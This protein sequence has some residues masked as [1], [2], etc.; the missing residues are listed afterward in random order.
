MGFRL[1]MRKRKR[2]GLWV[3]EAGECVDPGASGIAE[4]EQLGHLVKGFAGSVVKGPPKQRIRPV[5][6]RGSMRRAGEIKVRVPAGD[7]QREGPPSGESDGLGPSLE[8]RPATLRSSSEAGQPDRHP[9]RRG[10][11]LHRPTSDS[12]CASDRYGG[13][14]RP[15]SD[16]RRIPCQ[17][18]LAKD[19]P[20]I[21]P[22]GSAHLRH[23]C[24]ESQPRAKVSDLY[25][26]G[27]QLPCRR[28]FAFRSE[29]VHQSGHGESHLDLL[30]F[31]RLWSRNRR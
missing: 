26:P 29:P 11:E 5:M 24:G 20:R 15:A 28:S 21:L 8:N 30:D 14:T 2:H 19:R 23:L 12:G 22:A 4:A 17:G 13:R 27:F 25:W 10:V 18:V 1:D 7:D 9:G 31:F 16:I 6:G 3:A